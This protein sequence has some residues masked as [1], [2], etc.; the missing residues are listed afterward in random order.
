M[1]TAIEE[2]NQ[3]GKYRQIILLDW[4]FWVPL[5]GRG[6]RHIRT[7]TMKALVKRGIVKTWYENKTWYAEKVVKT[8][9]NFVKGGEL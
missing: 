8:N 1:V 5:L 6:G 9:C 4:A 3:N 2:L 7:D